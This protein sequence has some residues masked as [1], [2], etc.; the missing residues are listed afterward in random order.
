MAVHIMVVITFN[1]TSVSKTMLI[2]FLILICLKMFAQ[3]KI[4][5]IE[6]DNYHRNLPLPSIDANKLYE[7]LSLLG[8]DEFYQDDAKMRDEGFYPDKDISLPLDKVNPGKTIPS[9]SP[10]GKY[11]LS[12][13][14]QKKM[15]S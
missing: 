11:F 15:F 6:N 4:N 10:I 13:N 8:V 12:A 2:N 1:R 9:E 5:P 14:F 7:D 3:G